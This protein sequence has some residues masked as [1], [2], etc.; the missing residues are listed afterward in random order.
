MADSDV[1]CVVYASGGEVRKVTKVFIFTLSLLLLSGCSD[2][3]KFV[4]EVNHDFGSFEKEEF[5]C[6]DGNKIWIY[7]VGKDQGGYAMTS[8]IVGACEVDGYGN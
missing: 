7:G 2:F 6:I 3:S 1:A 8:Q 5:K 4:N